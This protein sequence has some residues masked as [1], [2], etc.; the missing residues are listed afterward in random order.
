VVDA[1]EV[2]GGDPEAATPDHEPAF[3][4]F[5]VGHDDSIWIV[6]PDAPD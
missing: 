5:I 4:Q 6:L 3:Q 1:D 2:S